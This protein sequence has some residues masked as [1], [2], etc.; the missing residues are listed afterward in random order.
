M[1]RIGWFIF[2]FSAISLFG[3]QPTPI[4]QGAVRLPFLGVNLDAGADF[5]TNSTTIQLNAQISPLTWNYSY[6][7][8]TVQRPDGAV[9]TMGNAFAKANQVTVDLNGVYRF[10]IVARSGV[11]TISDEI[12]VAVNASLNGAP[13]ITSIPDVTVNEDQIATTASFTI[14]DDATPVGS[15]TV[16]PVVTSGSQLVQSVT[17]NGT[18]ATR[19]LSIVPKPN[20]NGVVQVSVSVTDAHGASSSTTAQATF[21][22]QN[23]SPI[24]GAIGTKTTPEDTPIAFTLSSTDLE[25]TSFTYQITSG[26]TILLPPSGISL[27][28]SLLTLTPAPNRFGTN[29]VTVIVFDGTGGSDSETF[30]FRVT[31]QNDVPSMSAIPDPN[32]VAVGVPFDVSYQAIDVEDV[33]NMTY[34]RAT[35]NPAVVPLSGIVLSGTGTNRIATITGASAGTANVTLTATDSLG[36]SAQEIIAVVISASPNTPPSI[37]APAPQTVFKNQP[38]PSANMTV[39]DAESPVTQLVT[40]ASASSNPSLIPTNRVTITGNTGTRAVSASPISNVVG[41]ATI[42]LS[43]RDGAN[44]VT[45]ASWNVTVQA[46]NYPPIITGPSNQTMNEDGTLVVQATIVDYDTTLSS[47]ITTGTSGNPSLV[48]NPPS[49]GSGST[50]NF[51]L[52]PVADANGNTTITLTANDGTS[53]AQAQFNLTVQ[54]QNDLPTITGLVGVQ[55]APNTT[56]TQTA[57][58]GDK[59]SPVANLTLTGSSAN[60]TLVPNSNIVITGSTSSRQVAI[61]PASGQTGSTTITIVVNDGT[62]GSTAISFSFTVQGDVS[63]SDRFGAVN[64]SASNSGTNPASPWSVQRVLTWI[65]TNTVSGATAWMADGTWSGQRL[66]LPN[67]QVP[68]RFRSMNRPWGGKGFRVDRASGAEAAG[69]NTFSGNNVWVWDVVSVNSGPRQVNADRGGGWYITTRGNNRLINCWV[70]DAENGFAVQDSDAS[71]TG[72]FIVSG[73]LSYG[74]GKVIGSDG[75]HGHGHYHQSKGTGGL[76]IKDGFSHSNMGQ[77]FQSSGTDGLLFRDTTLSRSTFFMNGQPGGSRTRNVLFGLGNKFSGL[78]VISNRCYYPAASGGGPNLYMCYP[79]V[80]PGT[81]GDPAF[82]STNGLVRGNYLIGGDFR[83]GRWEQLT[84]MENTFISSTQLPAVHFYNQYSR[85]GTTFDTN[86]LSGS[87][88]ADT[89][90]SLSAAQRQSNFGFSA[91]DVTLSGPPS[92]MRFWLDLDEYDPK[93]A[94]LSVSNPSGASTATISLAGFLSNGDPYDVYSV[95]NPDVRFSSG[96]YTGP[97]VLPMTGFPMF[98]MVGPVPAAPQSPEPLFG[99]FV[100]IKTN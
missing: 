38:T 88:T 43:V 79:S 64:G 96:V 51:T 89:L 42:I 31:S 40:W 50:R 98:S 10:Q 74:N 91:H 61:T 99:A 48:P 56:S 4:P 75:N 7:W 67:A 65:S 94:R 76:V 19:T 21:V 97:I 39:S 68:T 6:E 34:T 11:R 83:F 27:A 8:T 35:D 15:L 70:R 73:F 3:Q 55:T 95:T 60:T 26:D 25:S 46:T 53:S 72:N 85:T 12:Q 36:A 86:T 49:I 93:L 92:T 84:V 30:S 57:T 44:Q 22:A 63:S 62:G 1:I 78:T 82:I 71:R 13:T 45:T 20:S 80:N 52:T 41:T 58:V 69:A 54:A 16:L 2:I 37:T 18:G 87:F 29:T 81:I 14:G 28:G 9:V 32:P 59:E 100:I 5:T 24:L 23:D 33:G 77:G 17:V 90:G 47:V 66:V